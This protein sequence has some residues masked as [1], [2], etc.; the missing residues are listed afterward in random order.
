MSQD[1]WETAIYAD[2]PWHYFVG[3]SEPESN[4]RNVEFNDSDWEVG[5]GS[6]GYGDGDDLTEIES[7][8]SLYIR[9]TF[10]IEDMAQLTGMILHADYD[11]GFIAYV[12]GVE[13][14]RSPNMGSPEI[15]FGFDDEAWENHEAAMYQGGIPEAYS[16]G[17]DLESILTNGLNVFAVQVHNVNYS[18]IC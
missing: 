6:I 10:N 2:D 17:I 18:S 12:N 1:H 8:I 15:F 4:W 3:E 5:P 11:D 7:T 13:I 14:S 9:R 16:A